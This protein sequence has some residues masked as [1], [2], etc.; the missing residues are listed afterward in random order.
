ME[1]RKESKYN[2]IDFNQDYGIIGFT[3]KDNEQ[4]L[5]SRYE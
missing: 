1:K 4:Y 3:D 2:T 5:F